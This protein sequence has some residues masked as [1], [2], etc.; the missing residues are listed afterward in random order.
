[1]PSPQMIASEKPRASRHPEPA[2]LLADARIRAVPWRDLVPLRRVE[3]LQAEA[4][5]V[6]SSGE[7]KEIK[8]CARHH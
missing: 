6:R 7:H 1:M 5:L 2:S 8:E 3:R 4:D